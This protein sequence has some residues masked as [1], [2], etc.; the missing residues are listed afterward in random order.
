MKN[1]TVLLGQECETE[2]QSNFSAAQIVL[3]TVSSH[4]GY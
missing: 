1:M 2:E 4:V 3:C